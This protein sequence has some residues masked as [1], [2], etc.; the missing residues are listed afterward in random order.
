MLQ[1]LETA[2]GVAPR[3][4]LAG[5]GVSVQALADP[6]QRLTLEQELELFTRI[7]QR[8]TDPLLGIRVGA[9]LSKLFAA[10]TIRL[11]YARLT[12]E[13]AQRG[14]RRAPAQT[15]LEFLPGLGRAFPGADEDARRVTDAY[16]NA[17]Y[18]E[19]PD[20]LDKLR[21]IQAAWARMRRIEP[22]VV[23]PPVAPIQ[24]S[25]T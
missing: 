5:T 15:P 17:H 3:D 13:A 11:I 2:Q 19:V 8:N 1:Q 22:P 16:I 7:A 25:K 6:T 4:I 10:A 23:A 21:A 12:A 18:G 24:T 14:E 20:T 9:R